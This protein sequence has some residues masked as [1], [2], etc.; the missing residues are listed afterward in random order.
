MIV[1]FLLAMV[2]LPWIAN[3]TIS[4]CAL[5][6]NSGASCASCNP[7]YQTLDN[8]VSCTKI[9]CSGMAYCDLCDTTTT[10]LNCQFG[11]ELNAGKT[12]CSKISCTDNQ[13]NLCSSA[14]SGT[15][16]NCLTGYYVN[17]GHTCTSCSDTI[18]QC[19]YCY[20]NSSTLECT[21][22]ASTYYTATV[23]TCALCSAGQANCANCD[24][25]GAGS[26]WCFDCVSTHFI[27]NYATGVCDLC[28]VGITNCT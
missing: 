25:R 7:G 24:S 13:C 28:N 9:D 10:C 8:G 23:S 5:M 17:S 18:S 22:C 12:A 14:A 20:M 19:N 21:A 27:S 11:Y 4:N 15:C 16:Y 3:A 2:T 26:L 1:C 6:D